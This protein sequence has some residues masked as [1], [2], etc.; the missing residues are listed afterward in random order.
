MTFNEFKSIIEEKFP[1]VTPQQMEQFQLL[2]GLYREWNAKIN[3]VSRKDI[4]ELYRHH[5]LHSLGIAA[6]LK[7]PPVPRSRI[8]IGSDTLYGPSPRR[9]SYTSGI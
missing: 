2:D 8:F 6:Y 5:V 9:R 7:T 4:D 3:V 1:E